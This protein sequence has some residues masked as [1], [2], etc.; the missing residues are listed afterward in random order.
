MGPIAP[1]YHWG[2]LRAA[3]R[4]IIGAGSGRHPGWSS[5]DRAVLDVT[6][7]S[8]FARYWSPSSRS[9]FLAEHVWEHL[10]PEEA[11]RANRNCY[12]F[13]APGGRFRVAVPDGFHPDAG[14]RERVRPGGTGPGAAD[15]KVLYD[16]R[17][18]M[19]SFEEAGFQ[20]RLLEYWDEDGHFHAAAWSAEDGPIERSA[21]ADPRNAE[22]HLA[23]TSLIIDGIRE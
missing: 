4:I 17:S 6:R 9:A 11:S 23:Y 15:H 19:S 14:Y 1:L 18:L 2:R 3:Q 13:L 8:D 10:T 21:R 7:R 20:T 12:E 22:G 16:Y 5:T